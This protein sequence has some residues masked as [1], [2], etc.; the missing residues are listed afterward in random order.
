MAYRRSRHRRHHK[1][2]KAGLRRS[3]RATRKGGLKDVKLAKMGEKSQTPK[4]QSKKRV[5]G[6]DAEAAAGCVSGVCR[7]LGALLSGGK[8]RTKRAGLRRSKRA[9]LKRGG[10]SRRVKRGGDSSYGPLIPHSPEEGHTQENSDEGE[11]QHDGPIHTSSQ[12]TAP[13]VGTIL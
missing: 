2:K 11:N 3:K 12:S 4:P 1:S 6:Q 5:S 10:L 9:G 7:G 8:R 13:P